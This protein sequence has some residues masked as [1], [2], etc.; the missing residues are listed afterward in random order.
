MGCNMCFRN[1]NE[2]CVI[3][4]DSFNELLQKIKDVDGIILGSPVHFSGIA[5]TMKCFLDRAFYVSGANGN[6]FRHKVGTAI[7][8]VRR[9]GGSHTLDGLYHYLTY[10]EMLI[11]S[12]N[13]W[14]IIH[15]L[16]AGEAIQ[17]AEGNQIMRILGKNMAWLLKMREQTKD[18][19][20]A[21]ETETKIM[22]N[23]IR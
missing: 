5:G 8:A 14:N 6:W 21:P 23:F 9:S 17:D 4:N 10:S 13:Y 20:A 16:K 11:P 15:G 1:K 3:T 2:K 19:L 12:S 22:T 18:T 7:V